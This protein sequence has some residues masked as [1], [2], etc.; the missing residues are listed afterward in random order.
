M[1]AHC[2]CVVLLV[3]LSQGIL[4]FVFCSF[5]VV[6]FCCSSWAFSTTGSLEGAYFIK[7]GQLKS[8]SEQ[9][10]V[11]CDTKSDQG[12]N[13]G[14]MDNAFAFIKKNKG[15]CTESSYPYTGVDGSCEK[16]CTDVAGA[17]VKSFTDV[18][19][20]QKA[21]MSAV[22]QQPVSIAIEADQS[23]FQ[24]YKSGVFTAA[25]GTNL[26]HGVLAVG[27]GKMGKKKYWKVKNSWGETW[28]LD[29]FIL[30]Q[31]G[32]KQKGG[33]CGILNSASYPTL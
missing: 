13:G 30:L 28:G 1:R 25:C 22:A 21:M 7:T 2:V 23:A 18:G 14:L 32:K 12:C 4:L 16:S 31:R 6:I 5:F 26:D 29:G 33:Q 3:P 17:T 11:D 27:Y 9:Q 24:F 20:T 19:K 15:L 8:F 10:L